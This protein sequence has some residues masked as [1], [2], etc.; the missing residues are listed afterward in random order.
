[1]SAKYKVPWWLNNYPVPSD[2][3]KPVLIKQEDEYYHNYGIGRGGVMLDEIFISTDKISLTAYTLPPGQCFNPPDVHP[4]NEPY[5]IMKG[6]AT[7]YN[8]ETGVAVD[9]KEGSAVFIPEGVWHQVFNF[10]EKDVYICAMVEGAI[11]DDKAL[12]T[13]KDQKEKLKIIGYKNE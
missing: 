13:V 3:K 10:T 9:A 2:K 6:T 1:M 8:P 5:F 11:W 12:E 7:L 4:A